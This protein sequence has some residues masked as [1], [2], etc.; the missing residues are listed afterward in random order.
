L[1]VRFFAR[2]E[3][4]WNDRA[5]S[6]GPVQSWTAEREVFL[7]TVKGRIRFQPKSVSLDANN[8]FVDHMNFQF[9]ATTGDIRGLGTLGT[10]LG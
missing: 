7:V 6:W 2:F 1:V 9:D 4:A 5:G 8:L 10:P 3:D